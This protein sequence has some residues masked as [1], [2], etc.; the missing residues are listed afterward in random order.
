MVI[1]AVTGAMLSDPRIADAAQ[2]VQPPSWTEDGNY[3]RKK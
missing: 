1:V 2:I 3:H